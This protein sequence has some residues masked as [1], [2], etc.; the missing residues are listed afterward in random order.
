MSAVVG[1][2]VAQTTPTVL[3]VEVEDDERYLELAT[4]LRLKNEL[5]MNLQRT[6]CKNTTDFTNLLDRT[7]QKDKLINDLQNIIMKLQLN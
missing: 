6:I 4:E 1:V 5:V 2:P 7:N 3:G